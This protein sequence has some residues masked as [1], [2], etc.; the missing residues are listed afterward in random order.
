MS[1][2]RRN[3]VRLG[4]S[5]VRILVIFVVLA[6]VGG[7]LWLGFQW[8]SGGVSQADLDAKIAAI[9]ARGEPIFPSDFDR[10][11]IPDDQNAAHFLRLAA[12]A[13]RLSKEQDELLGEMHDLPLPAEQM[14]SIGQIV[15]AHGETF[16]HVR[17]ARGCP[18]VNWGIHYRSPIML[19]KYPHLNKAK[20]LAVLLRAAAFY[21]HQRGN[22]AAAVELLRDIQLIAD[23][24]NRQSTLIGHLVSMGIWSIASDTSRQLALVLA[25]GPESAA[26]KQ[27]GP[28]SR[29]QVEQLIANFLDEPQR[30]KGIVESWQGERMAS[31]DMAGHVAEQTGNRFWAAG[32]SRTVA[33]RSMEAAEAAM[34]A[35]LEEDWPAAQPK[36]PVAPTGRSPGAMMTAM[37]MPSHQMACE[38]EFRVLADRR[39]AAIALGTRLYAVEHDGRLPA[40]LAELAPKYLPAVPADPFASASRPIGFLPNPARLYSVS[41]NGIDEQ[42]DEKGA[43]KGDEHNVW[44]SP[45]AV[46]H[47][48]P[49]P[50]PATT[51]PSTPD[52]P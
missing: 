31:L 40:S 20:P 21:E 37:L 17:R 11:A 52:E 32:I 10:P 33:L 2:G 45:D 27:A 22:D 35:S 48:T 23:A 43:W 26:A 51:R 6:L 28:A 46:F 13:M 39:T 3:R 29:K 16:A 49:Q 9:Q 8:L 18:E 34:A 5:T 25:I 19:M 47:L 14:E 15:A 4:I 38:R 44:R 12:S 24:T 1:Q 30:K 42:A 41:T 50:R 36:L 7:G